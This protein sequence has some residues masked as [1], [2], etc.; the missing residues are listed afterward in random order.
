MQKRKFLKTFVGFVLIITA[1]GL[2][3]CS[4]TVAWHKV[5]LDLNRPSQSQIHNLKNEDAGADMELQRQIEAIMKDFFDSRGEEM[6]Y[7]TTSFTYGFDTT[8]LGLVMIVINSL[9]AFIPTLVGMPFEI[10]D[11]RLHAYLRL[12]DSQG[13]LMQTFQNSRHFNLVQGLYYGTPTKKAGKIYSELL[14]DLLRQ[15]SG[16]ASTINAMLEAAGPITTE[17]AAAARSKIKD[18]EKNQ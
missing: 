18:S 17:N 11:Y 3:A 4:T 9:T 8:P 12:Y 13:N 1:T 6:G 16:D 14:E 15:A 7:Y 10:Y 5:K 2:S